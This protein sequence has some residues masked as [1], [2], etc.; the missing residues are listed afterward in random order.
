MTT[1]LIAE[2]SEKLKYLEDEYF[3]REKH[4]FF[5]YQSKKSFLYRL[6]AKTF[7][8]AKDFYGRIFNRGQRINHIKFR[9]TKEQRKYFE[10]LIL[11]ILSLR[12]SI[13]AS[14]RANYTV[15]SRY[16]KSLI[17]L[18]E[19]IHELSTIV[20][21]NGK[22]S[23][24]RKSLHPSAN[25]WWWFLDENPGS[26]SPFL[27]FIAVGIFS[28]DICLII[29]ISMRVL[30]GF[31]SVAGTSIV[32]TQGVLAT[33]V[34]KGIFTKDGEDN[35]YKIFRMFGYPRSDINKLKLYLTLFLLAALFFLRQH[36]LPSLARNFNRK[37]VSYH[38]KGWILQA[39]DNY[40]LS[41]SINP[42][43]PDVHYNLGR[44]YDE[45]FFD[46]N[47]AKDEYLIAKNA[48]IGKAYS[49]LG[50]IYNLEK[51]HE[52]AIAISDSGLGLLYRRKDK[53]DRD[54][55]NQIHHDLLVTS[56]WAYYGQRLYSKSRTK[57]EKAIKIGGKDEASS[58]CILA[59]V[60]Q[61]EAF[62]GKESMQELASEKWRKC[63]ALTR[64]NRPEEN[65]WELV[66]SNC[67]DKKYVEVCK[68]NV[69]GQN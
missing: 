40:G 51:K 54:I 22:L 63:L 10:L 60:F 48:G 2:L 33:V 64:S 1:I 55:F 14:Y 62:F 3:D 12:D 23:I 15:S 26:Y 4:V 17:E 36:I 47:K 41:L 28:L 34:G 5:L 27:S 20:V 44:I 39:K 67:L 45:N 57:L 49:A 13:E 42:N 16:Q 68:K 18:D 7:L 46:Y 29:E 59:H 21:N 66:A 24:W 31:F 56:G 58:Q 6:P 11:E 8:I 35:L 19:K 52:F 37:G 65:S 53:Y 32:I 30:S 50:R 38:E 9:L 43:R 61:A 69:L 25:N